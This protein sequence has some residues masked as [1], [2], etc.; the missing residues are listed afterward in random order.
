M[1]YQ[2][3]N[4]SEKKSAVYYDGSCPMCTVI[5]NKIEDSA[6]GE[7]FSMRDITKE[8]LPQNFTRACVEKEIH[9]VVAGKIYKNAEA[10]LKILE[11]YPVWRFF[12]WIG[13][14]P[15]IKQLL[16]IG[17]NFVAANRYFLFGPASRI[18]WLKV[19][20]GLGFI[21]G[22]LLSL[23]LWI[24]SRFYPLTPIQ[25]IF[26]PIPYPID[27]IILLSLFGLLAAAILSSKPKLYIWASVAVVSLLAFLDQQ[28][29]QPWVYQY[30]FMLATLGLFSW[31]WA[32]V[33]AK[34]KTLNVC[35]FIV[36]SI[37]FWSGLQKVNPEFMSS[38]FPWMTAPITQFFTD[39]AQYV[40][41]TFGLFVPFIE[42]G[43]G[44]GLMTK[45]FRSVAIWLALAMCVFVLWTIGPFGH[46]WNRVVWPWNITMAVLVVLLFAKTQTVPLRQIVWVKNY[47]FHKIILVVFGILPLFY[48][49]NMWDSYLSWSLY[50][51]TTNESVVYMSDQVK[52]RLPNYL[53]QFVQIDS[54][55][56][57]VLP[58]SN[59]AFTELNVPPYP[60]TRIFKNV[61][62]SICKVAS[63]PREVE[64]VMRGRLSWFYRDGQQVLNCSQLD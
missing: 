42:M 39:P 23:K 41:Y 21:I 56:R 47:T 48:F 53:Q 31:K 12:V 5:V 55:D 63:D 18:Y 17:Y 11:E 22:L 40:F 62:R 3:N 38:V 16:P 24:S 59:W 25:P 30:T 1:N 46:N 2:S 13:R 8:L 19:V 34:N 52:E 37:Y 20:V 6:K 10:I 33:E 4:N 27:W 49:F 51:G 60:E 58:I 26:P 43:I 57:N 35:R 44:V 32:D 28:R 61:A 64:L 45:K 50:S 36:A 9:V 54:R 7:K 14:L 15:L 29:L